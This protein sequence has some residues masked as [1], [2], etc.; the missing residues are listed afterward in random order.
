MSR[1]DDDGQGRV[2]DPSADPSGDRIMR[3]L[4]L[5]APT[6]TEE[7]VRAMFTFPAFFR[8]RADLVP[9]VC[10]WIIACGNEE[11][12]ALFCAERLVDASSL[13]KLVCSS[14]RPA[15]FRIMKDL[16]ITHWPTVCEEMPTM[17]SKNR[18]HLLQQCDREH[19]D[20]QSFTTSFYAAI[21]AGALDAVAFLQPLANMNPIEKT[22]H[23]FITPV[24][25]AIEHNQPEV[26]RHLLSSGCSA[27]MS[28]GRRGTPLHICTEFKRLECARIV[29]SYAVNVNSNERWPELTPIYEAIRQSDMDM[30]KLLIEHGARPH[31]EYTIAR[32]PM[33]RYLLDH[34]GP[35]P[36][37]RG[38]EGTLLHYARSDMAL[39]RHLVDVGVRIDVRDRHGATPLHNASD[40][41]E[42][43]QFY[44]DRG[45]DINDLNESGQNIMFRYF[46]HVRSFDPAHVDWLIAQGAR[47][48]LVSKRGAITHCM[49][50]CSLDR[51]SLIARLKYL[52]SRGMDMNVLDANGM[53]W[54]HQY[55]RWTHVD[56]FQ[57]ML[58]IFPEVDIRAITRGNYNMI[59]FLC[60]NVYLSKR[61]HIVNTL[62]ER[63]VRPDIVDVNGAN[64]LHL[65]CTKQI[66][67]DDLFQMLRRHCSI[68]HRNKQ[69]ETILHVN[70]HRIQKNLVDCLGTTDGD[71]DKL[72][73]NVVDAR[74]NTIFDI[75]YYCWFD[76][77]LSIASVEQ[78]Q[79][80]R[81]KTM[82]LIEKIHRSGNEKHLS[83]LERKRAYRL[84]DVWRWPHLCS[85]THVTIRNAENKSLLDVCDD[86]AIRMKLICWGID[87]KHCAS[88]TE[89]E[90]C[91]A[92]R[93][94]AWSKRIALA[95][96]MRALRVEQ[97]LLSYDAHVVAPGCTSTTR[98]CATPPFEG[99]VGE[100]LVLSHV[101]LH[102]PIGGGAHGRVF[103]AT[104][105]EQTIAVKMVSTEEAALAEILRSWWLLNDHVV[106]TLGLVRIES[107]T[108]IAMEYCDRGSILDS[109]DQWSSLQL[110]QHLSSIANVLRGLGSEHG[111]IKPSNILIRGSTPVLC[112]FA[113]SAGTPAYVP[114]DGPHD[115]FAFGLTVLS[116]LAGRDILLA[117]T[118]DPFTEHLSST[119]LDLLGTFRACLASCLSP[120]R[121]D[122][123][124]MARI[125]AHMELL[126]GRP[127]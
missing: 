99:A 5:P 71:A 60:E 72:Y 22:H 79:A 63:G 88:L 114:A 65:M 44:L 31:D 75:A 101:V 84:E 30:T 122:R 14:D 24:F 108:G 103:K 6:L 48:D 121:R 38:R 43:V 59:T 56:E 62:M 109:H 80:A 118:E 1:E 115:V 76:D 32:D 4:L 29:L 87:T 106:C 36:D 10:S 124:T 102:E 3:S 57:S 89:E 126:F 46:M 11:C 50:W 19:C 52:R 35:L 47:W 127:T 23:Q 94:R 51:A 15:L 66:K 81:C 95:R 58:T 28:V 45:I 40:S 16:Q 111:D 91:V 13:T 21:R 110:L 9:A 53:N 116:T 112:D 64:L 82:S 18:I 85:P 86:A 39:V 98:R 2:A 49:M 69:G 34:I 93:I 33:R 20:T 54:M 74:G 77:F 25:W 27:S 97:T 90:A 67:D 125:S 61:M 105:R 104:W 12:F 107:R 96:R 68:H 17:A 55:M 42:A 7:V 119:T 78:I 100:V 123:P 73:I 26:L 70:Q 117:D 120:L 37:W 83:L 8:R 41:K 92:K 113:V